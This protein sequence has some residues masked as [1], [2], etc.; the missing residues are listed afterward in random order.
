[1]EL[2]QRGIKTLGDFVDEES[3]R[4]VT[5]RAEI[6]FEQLKVSESQPAYIFLGG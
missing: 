3:I 4:E 6:S 2:Q 1:M 5:Q